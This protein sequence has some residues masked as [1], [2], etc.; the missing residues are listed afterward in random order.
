MGDAFN[1]GRYFSKALNQVKAL[2][3]PYARKQETVDAGWYSILQN[4][5]INIG[6]VDFRRPLEV[7]DGA[8]KISIVCIYRILMGLIAERAPYCKVLALQNSGNL[9]ASAPFVFVDT[10]TNRLVVVKNIENDIA[11]I[12]EDYVPEDISNLLDKTRT[13]SYA[14]VYLLHEKAE[15]QFI[16]PDNDLSKTAHGKNVHSLPWLFS[17]YFGEDYAYFRDELYKYTVAINE[18]IGYSVV[19]SLNP[20]ALVSFKKITERS[21]YTFNYDQVIHKTIVN[22]NGKRFW[23]KNIDECNKLR[24]QYLVDGAY[25]ILMS[26]RDYAESLITAEW[27]LDSMNKAHAIDLTVI[28]TGYFKAMEQLLFALIKLRDPA[29]DSDSTLGDYATFYKHKRD[30]I[31]RNDVDWTTRNFVFEAIYEYADLR[32]GYFHKHNIHDPSKIQEIRSAT[33]MLMYLILGCQSFNDSDYASLGIPNLSQGDDFS[34]LCEYI[35]FHKNSIFCV[36]PNGYP[37]QWIRIVPHSDISQAERDTEYCPCI[38]YNVLG[39]KNYGRFSEKYAPLCIWE[40]K[41]KITHAQ[42]LELDYEKTLLVF[43]EGK[44]VGPAIAEAEDFTY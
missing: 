16:A 38:Y 30:I 37:E 35:Q 39:A 1:Y 9:A 15:L 13:T 11:L 42:T 22:R 4:Q 3:D 25:R 19:R 12:T 32:N 2:R 8:N 33:Y 27:L 43:N 26:D 14:L 41:L 40:G 24:Q 6:A 21:L 18:Y 17:T 44:Y 7:I 23:L 20:S 29:F 28:G 34:K 31:L 10:K 5:I 36:K